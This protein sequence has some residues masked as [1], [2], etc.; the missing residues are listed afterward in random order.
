[1][2]YRFNSLCCTAVAVLFSSGVLGGQTRTRIV[3]ADFDR[4]WTAAVEVAKEGYYLDKTDKR[5][6]K[7]SLRTSPFYG[8]RLD[9]GF[10]ALS[11]GK[12]R[13]LVEVRRNYARKNE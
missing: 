5:Q 8:Y 2:V 4:V 11:R 3:A 9:I 13:L 7:L 1:M 12:T 6:G 10:Q